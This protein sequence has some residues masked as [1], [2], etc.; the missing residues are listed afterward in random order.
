MFHG[1]P[2]WHFATLPA[3]EMNLP[4]CGC[5]LVANM[6]RLDIF[7]P[8]RLA[9]TL[10]CLGTAA[11]FAPAADWPQWRGPKRDN[12]CSETGLLQQ[13]PEGGPKLAWTAA[14]LGDGYSGVAVVGERIYTLGDGSDGCFVRA[15]DAGTGKILWSARVGNSGG[16]GGFPGP[17][18]TPT[19]EGAQL[20][21]LGQFGDLVCLE[22]AGGKELWRH[23]FKDEMEGKMMSGWGYAESPMVDGGRVIC[24][25]GGPKG[26]LAAFDL[27][28][29]KLAWRSEGF[30]DNAAYCSMLVETIGGARQYVQLTD[31]SVA[32]VAAND[33]RLLWRAPRPGKTAVIPTPIFADN[34]VFVTSG[35]GIGCNLFKVTASDGQF[36]AEPVY[37]NKTMITQLGGVVKVGGHLF[38]YTDSKGWTCQEFQS[39]K[40]VWQDNARLGKGS[41]LAVDGQLILRAEKDKGTVVLINATT[42]GWAEQ[43]RF[44]QPERS[45]KNSWPPPVIAHGRLYLRDQDKLLSY[46][47]KAR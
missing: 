46:D 47:V 21:V 13:W 6:K 25:P 14:G 42:T 31:A 2:E 45:D 7:E 43:G 12:I 5:V 8:Y 44:D 15:L 36:S 39:G 24:T 41:V 16:G 27:A 9:C 37:A 18:C 1:N 34:G 38:G 30:T 23:N 35:Y 19:V 26:T 17:R 4:P 20:V 28:T 10:L 11:Q 22:T 33:G 32:G 3:K 29:G 40:L